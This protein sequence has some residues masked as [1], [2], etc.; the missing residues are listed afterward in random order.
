MISNN[1]L[2]NRLNAFKNGESIPEQPQEPF[3]EQIDPT[4]TLITSGINLVYAI[5]RILGYGYAIKTIFATDWNFWGWL[6]VGFSIEVLT[7]K[8]LSLFEK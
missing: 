6:A 8:I 4:V 1:A 3:Y 2:A 5:L 7:I